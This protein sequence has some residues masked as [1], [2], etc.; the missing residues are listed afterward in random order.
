MVLDLPPGF[1][2]TLL[3]HFLIMK[4]AGLGILNLNMIFNNDIK[5]LK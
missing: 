2:K 1:D 3:F 5:I 4:V